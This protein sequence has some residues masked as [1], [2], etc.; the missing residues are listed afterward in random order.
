MRGGFAMFQRCLY[1]KTGFMTVVWCFLFGF[2]AISVSFGQDSPADTL[3]VQDQAVTVFLDRMSSY[4]DHITKEIPFVN[5]VRDSKEADVHVLLTTQSTGSGGTE[6]TLTFMGQQTYTGIDDTLTFAARQ[7]DT[8]DTR[9]NSIVKALKLGLMPYVAKT[10]LANDISITYTKKR[11]P[12]KVVDKW[13]YWVFK[14]SNSGYVDGEKTSKYYSLNGSLSA[15]R[16]TPEWKIKT[17][18]STSYNENIYDVG[19]RTISSIS[20]S[21]SFSGF[22]AKS[23][24]D[25]WSVGMGANANSSLYSNTKLSLELAPALEYDVFPYAESTRREFTFQYRVEYGNIH[26]NEITLYD[27]MRENLMNEQ[28]SV[29]LYRTE[30][31]GSLSASL[32]GSHY[33]HDLNKN[34]LSLYTSVSL[35]LFEGFSLSLT[36]DVSRIHDQLSLPRRNASDEDVLLRRKQLATQYSYYSSIGFT[37][38]FGSIYSNVVNPRF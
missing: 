7:S 24:G 27:K 22:V 21:N 23:L 31:W 12:E 10:P 35:R 6:Y 19:S 37:Y 28:L 16:I 32:S 1:V 4:Q 11:A 14:I 25:H 20:R 34:N 2:M 13:D 17:S 38:T 26:Y 5:Y 3:S 18:Y 33:L 15:N 29:S 36:G 30:K 8:D 9:R